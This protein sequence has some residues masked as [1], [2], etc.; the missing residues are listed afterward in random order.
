MTLETI[1]SRLW[2]SPHFR[3]LRSLL[4]VNNW[5][6]W[7]ANDLA[8]VLTLILSAY[9]NNKHSQQ[10]YVPYQFPY[11]YHSRSVLKGTGKNHKP[12]LD[13]LLHIPLL[14]VDLQQSTFSLTL[15][16]VQYWLFDYMHCMHFVFHLFISF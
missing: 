7:W 6:T 9:I 8:S 14:S 12:K 1:K 3:G 5:S 13:Q 4:Q 16:Q 10:F 15:P 11:I 2:L